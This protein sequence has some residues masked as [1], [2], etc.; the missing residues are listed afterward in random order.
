MQWRIGEFKG[1]DTGTPVFAKANFQTST[2][3]RYE[4][5]HGGVEAFNNNMPLE[6]QVT[7]EVFRFDLLMQMQLGR[8]WIKLL[9]NQPNGASYEQ[10][11]IDLF[12]IEQA[13]NAQE[14]SN[15][16]GMEVRA[17]AI[18]RSMNGGSLYLHLTSSSGIDA[19]DLNV[20]M[21][22]RIDPA[23]YSQVNTCIVS[24]LAFFQ[25]TYVLPDTDV[26][27][28][29]HSTLE[30]SGKCSTP[31]ASTGEQ[32]T[33]LSANH[34]KGGTMDWYSFDVQ[35]DAA[36]LNEDTNVIIEDDVIRD[37]FLTRLPTDVSFPGIPPDRW[38]QIQDSERNFGIISQDKTDVFGMILADFMLT[39]N[40]DW[41]LV[42][43]KVPVGSLTKVKSIVVKDVFGSQ[44]YVGGDL[45]DTSASTGLWSMFN[46]TRA[47][48]T[49]KN[50]DQ[51]LFIPPTAIK[52]LES[53]PYEKVNFSRDEVAGLGW[54]IEVT[55]PDEIGGSR[56]GYAAGQDL[57]SYLRSLPMEDMVNINDETGTWDTGF[58][59]GLETGEDAT[60]FL[61][62]EKADLRYRLTTH[63]SE[64]WIPFVPRFVPN[65]HAQI[66]LQ[67]AR[68]PRILYSRLVADATMQYIE[69]RTKILRHG[70]DVTPKQPYYLKT[71]AL[72]KAGTYVTCT[73]KR[74]RWHNGSVHTW[75]G[76]KATIGRGLVLSDLQFDRIVSVI[77]E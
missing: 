6:I 37:K 1:E 56:D 33:V 7:K 19:A 16:N 71:Y 68:I 17:T 43:Y 2:L 45:L 27:S 70:L 61:T 77:E 20:F 65:D 55:I 42:P 32:Q 24:F 58:E 4:G 29:N 14:F 21:E 50:G 40:N 25:R 31:P 30:F 23:H 72:P 46:L 26:A 60:E 34:F 63:V 18:G 54:G 13:S 57:L 9:R 8:Y 67:R 3:T 35:A 22:N 74:A 73:Y 64:N 11:F 49:N 53:E 12:P 28:W 38:W 5:V 69:P 52:T 59:I 48:D 10:D 15:N 66:Q 51:R 76:R 39:Y 75:A 62:D 41:S 36:D 47:G 44:I